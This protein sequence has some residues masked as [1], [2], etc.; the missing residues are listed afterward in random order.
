MFLKKYKRGSSSKRRIFLTELLDFLCWADAD[1]KSVIKGF[2]RT[3]EIQ[4]LNQG[5]G[6]NRNRI[7]VVTK[8]RTLELEAGSTPLANKWR[9]GLELLMKY[10]KISEAKRQEILNSAEWKQNV[11]SYTDEHRNCLI[12][13]DVFKKWPTGQKNTFCFGQIYLS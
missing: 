9:M 2:V 7:Y 10:Q 8:E 6:A 11:K 1:N 4:E 3:E 5:F 12:T 13:G